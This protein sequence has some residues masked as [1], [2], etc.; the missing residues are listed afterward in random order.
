LGSIEA[1]EILKK[2]QGSWIPKKQKDT[3]MTHTEWMEKNKAKTIEYNM[4]P[5]RPSSR[6]SSLSKK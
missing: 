1:V 3:A 6:L 5:S 4:I 2:T